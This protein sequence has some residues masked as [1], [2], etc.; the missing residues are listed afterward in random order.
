VAQKDLTFVLDIVKTL[1]SIVI[2]GGVWVALLTYWQA[3]RNA[4]LQQTLSFIDVNPPR[5][6]EGQ[7]KQYKEMFLYFPERYDYPIKTTLSEQDARSFVAIATLPGDPL[8]PKYNVARQHLNYLEPIAFAYVHGLGDRK[9]LA[10]SACLSLVR[11]HKYFE[12]LID[13]FGERF[14]HLQPWQV[15]RQAVIQ[16]KAD[17]PGACAE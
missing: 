5:T 14:G 3:D 1:A 10:N 7:A 12:K 6:E 9:I 13:V 2:A 16:M 4:R 15:I 11:S 17:Y 8:Y